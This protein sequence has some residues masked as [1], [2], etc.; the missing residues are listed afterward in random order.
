M[1]GRF[2][3]RDVVFPLR[4]ATKRGAFGYPNLWKSSCGWIAPTRS[5]NNLGADTKY[6]D[7]NLQTVRIFASRGWVMYIRPI[8]GFGE[9]LSHLRA[10]NSNAGRF[11]GAVVRYVSLDPDFPD[12]TPHDS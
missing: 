8:I 2:P 10:S 11:S 1:N 5:E 7:L 9:R 3:W 6:R 4:G 12:M